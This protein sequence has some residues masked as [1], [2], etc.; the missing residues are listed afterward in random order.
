MAQPEEPYISLNCPEENDETRSDQ[1]ESEHLSAQQIVL[2]HDTFSHSHLSVPYTRQTPYPRWHEPVSERHDG[3]QYFSYYKTDHRDGSPHSLPSCLPSAVYQTISDGSLFCP[4]RPH[5]LPGSCSSSL[6]SLEAPRSLHS[7]VPSA[8]IYPQHPSY[9]NPYP[10]PPHCRPFGQ[11]QHHAAP[12]H[13]CDSRPGHQMTFRPSDPAHYRQVDYHSSEHNVCHKPKQDGPNITHLSQEHRKVFVT[14]EADSDKHLKEIIKFV[15]LLRNNGFDTHI[16][17]FEEQ[18]SSISKIDCMERYLNEKDYLIIIIISLRYY[19]TV[20][21]MNTGRDD[22]EKTSNTVYIHRQLQ[23][24]FI[25]NGS[26][27]YR[28]IPILF[29][30]ANKSY[31]PSWLRNTHI[32]SWP[33]DRD[34]ILLRLMRVEKYNPPPV[35]PL[36]TIVPIP[37]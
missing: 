6:I 4:S 10:H 8:Q 30:G 1:F 27:N 18:L 16:D 11:P 37:L 25:Q 12:V 2:R 28:F 14:Y 22:D 19:K 24:E 29:P 23:S 35:G 26:R 9:P 34:D 7:Y 32:Y 31:V 15:A 17:V 3:C 36:P 33:K 21:G 13:H 5:S 20:S